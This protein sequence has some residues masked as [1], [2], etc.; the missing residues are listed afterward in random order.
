MDFLQAHIMS[1][2]EVFGRDSV[3]CLIYPCVSTASSL[4]QSLT[5][6]IESI[7]N[8]SENLDSEISNSIDIFGTVFQLSASKIILFQAKV[9]FDLVMIK[10]LVEDLPVEN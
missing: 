10:S 9:R 7:A 5:S 2:A 3:A 1:T 8:G 6:R 4:F